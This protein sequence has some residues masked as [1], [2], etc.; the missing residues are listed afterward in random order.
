V[1]QI[2]KSRAMPKQSTGEADDSIREESKKEAI[3]AELFGEWQTEKYELPR[4]VG[5][6]VPR[7]SD[8]CLTEAKPDT[9]WFI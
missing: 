8:L 5:G 4:A 9:C 6:I 3:M 1:L 7:V 2:V